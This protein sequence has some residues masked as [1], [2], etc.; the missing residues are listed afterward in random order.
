MYFWSFYTTY[1]CEK[2]VEMYAQMLVVD[3]SRF[4]DFPERLDLP[5]ASSR[6][7]KNV[8]FSDSQDVFSKKVV[9]FRFTMA[10]FFVSF[11]I[12]GVGN[13]VD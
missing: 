7:P 8:F 2:C 9:P 12:N 1:T 13:N 5:V 4:G 6:N 10:F 3:N 11:R